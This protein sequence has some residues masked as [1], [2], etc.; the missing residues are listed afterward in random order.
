MLLMNT[1]KFLILFQLIALTPALSQE[2]S[3]KNA[4]IEQMVSEFKPDNI[5]A[6]EVYMSIPW[7]TVNIYHPYQRF[8]TE[9]KDTTNFDDPDI[10]HSATRRKIV[11]L[12][13]ALTPADYASFRRQIASQ[14][15]TTPVRTIRGKKKKGES[16]IVQFSTPLLSANKDLMIVQKHVNYRD[17]AGESTCTVYRM[18][19]GRWTEYLQLSRTAVSF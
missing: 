7:D 1:L 16:M 2:D 19:D 12:M 3:M 5:S 6:L 4:F 10:K 9:R 8:L 18:K 11:T 14:S 13:K 17:G 15:L